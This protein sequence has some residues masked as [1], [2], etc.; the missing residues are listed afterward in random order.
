M[1]HAESSLLEYP[2]LPLQR[3]APSLLFPS[4]KDFHCDSR[5]GGQSGPQSEKLYILS[6]EREVEE[7]L[8]HFEVVTTA[9]QEGG[10]Q[11]NIAHI[12]SLCF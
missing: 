7:L 1:F 9:T 3:G 10:D 4:Q 2:L 5:F 12:K 6:G 11:N 8:L